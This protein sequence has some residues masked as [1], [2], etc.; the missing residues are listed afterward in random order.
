MCDHISRHLIQKIRSSVS[1]NVR[2]WKVQIHLGG[3]VCASQFTVWIGKFQHTSK[4]SEDE[5][6]IYN[7]IRFWSLSI[8]WYIRSLARMS[9]WPCLLELVQSLLTLLLKSVAAIRLSSKCHTQILPLY[10]FPFLLYL[11]L[12]PKAENHKPKL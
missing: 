3:F 6:A 7:L 9:N 8:L 10:C 5:T 11:E 12:C 2:E 1:E 4:H